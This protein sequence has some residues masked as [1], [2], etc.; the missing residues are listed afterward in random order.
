[1]EII[2]IKIQNIH[3]EICKHFSKLYFLILLLARVPQCWV[4]KVRK[5]ENKSIKII[6]SAFLMQIHRD[7]DTNNTDTN[8][9]HKQTYINTNKTDTD[10]KITEK[11]RE[12]PF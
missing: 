6:F 12:F 2:T 4:V 7:T 10:I 11:K 8:T 9:A 1:M 5:E 3:R